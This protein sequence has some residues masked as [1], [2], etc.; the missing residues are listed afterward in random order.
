MNM[1]VS[2]GLILLLGWPAIA[3]KKTDVE[4]V[5]SLDLAQER[6][7]AEAKPLL[8]EFWASWCEPCRQM[9]RESWADPRV[10][11]LSRRYVA[12]SVDFDRVRELIGRYQ[13]LSI[14]A[15]ILTD[16]WG[17]VLT[18]REG[19]IR[20]TDLAGMLAEVPADFGP[21]REWHEKLGRNS[22]DAQALAGMGRFFVN[23]NAPRFA[24]RFYA[25]ALQSEGCDEQL[26]C[27][28]TLAIGLDH[29]VLGEWNEGRK[30]LRRF[31]K[32]FPA[33]GRRDQALLG[34]VLADYRQG[35]RLDARK[36]LAEMQKDHPGSENT[37]AAS[38][39]LNSGR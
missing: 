29:I 33:S 2:L 25:A 22:R 5:S 35:K 23:A 1:R 6:A 11:Q 15:V 4:W 19:L 13:V 36:T 34:I 27:D 12:V 10:V 28:L 17:N 26:R 14:P 32:E 37:A 20:P 7:Q 8:V 21:A 24:N 18:R 9:D 3:G 39:L 30:I 16:P 31:L 38:R